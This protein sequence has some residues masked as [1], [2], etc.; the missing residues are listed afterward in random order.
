[1]YARLLFEA[2]EA[3]GT[4]PALADSRLFHAK[5][6]GRDKVVSWTPAEATTVVL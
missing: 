2:V 1:M 5:L 6:T 4:R 3:V